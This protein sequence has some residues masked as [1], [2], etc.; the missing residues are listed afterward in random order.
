M[1][2]ERH[3][4]RMSDADVLREAGR[5]AASRRHIGRADMLLWMMIG[6]ALAV[7]ALNYIL[8]GGG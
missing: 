5:I 1:S 4:Q 7:T 2:D 6:A 8:G 3:S